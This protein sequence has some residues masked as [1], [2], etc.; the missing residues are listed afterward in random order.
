[1]KFG[2]VDKLT[3]FDTV[4]LLSFVGKALSI[5]TGSVFHG[6]YIHLDPLPARSSVLLCSSFHPVLLQPH[7]LCIVFSHD[8]VWGVLPTWG[9]W[10]AGQTLP[11]SDCCRASCAHVISEVR[12]LCNHTLVPVFQ[13]QTEQ[14]LKFTKDQYSAWP[15]KNKTC[16]LIPN[17]F[18]KSL[19]LLL[20]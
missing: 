19:T 17:D 15:H 20:K 14:N 12:G 16:I 1:M 4:V 18:I 2:S 8:Q 6:T 9:C 5:N 7:F 13:R 11:K 10:G 3:H